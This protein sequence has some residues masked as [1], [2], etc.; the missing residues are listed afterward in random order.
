MG[1]F[2]LAFTADKEIALNALYWI[3]NRISNTS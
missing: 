3:A 2:A 1:N